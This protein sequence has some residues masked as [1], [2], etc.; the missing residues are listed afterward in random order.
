MRDTAKINKE[1]RDFTKRMWKVQD[2]LT[3]NNIKEYVPWLLEQV[4]HMK[5]KEWAI[6]DSFNLRRYNFEVLLAFERAIRLEK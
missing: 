6:R 3:R 1:K 2:Y 5:G 4:P